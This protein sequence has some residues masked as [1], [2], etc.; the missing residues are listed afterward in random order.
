MQKEN[1]SRLDQTGAAVV[2]L[3][4]EKAKLMEQV[5]SLLEDMLFRASSAISD[6]KNEAMSMVR[7]FYT[8]KYVDALLDGTIEAVAY[9]QAA[10][11][12]RRAREL[13]Q[14]PVSAFL[15]ILAV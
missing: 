1:E 11:S 10:L 3:P 13:L 14:D 15:S 7:R 5:D 9:E 6:A 8:R 2:G 4:A 12:D